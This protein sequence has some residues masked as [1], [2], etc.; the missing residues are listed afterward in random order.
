MNAAPCSAACRLIIPPE[1]SLSYGA[2]RFAASD[3]SQF[4]FRLLRLR[5]GKLTAE[6]QERALFALESEVLPERPILFTLR[7]AQGPWG[8]GGD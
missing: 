1:W 8:E 6:S 2:P 3:C 4:Y 7:V 5:E